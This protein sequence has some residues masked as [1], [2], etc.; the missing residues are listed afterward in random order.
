MAS[1]FFGQIFR[2]T[3]FGESHGAGVGV[4]ID[5]CPAGLELTEQEIQEQLALRQPGKSPFTTPRA[6]KDKAEILSGLFEGKTTGAPIA[7]FIRNTDVD[8][9]PYSAIQQLVRP[10]HANFTYLAKYG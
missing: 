4:V 1:N 7:I 5:G 9:R 6:E 3:T 10:G 2:I 8:S